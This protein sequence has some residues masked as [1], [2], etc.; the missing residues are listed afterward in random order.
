MERTGKNR[1]GQQ[2]CAKRA[3]I[4]GKSQ[5]AND[6]HVCSVIGKIMNAKRQCAC[7]LCEMKQHSPYR[8]MA[9]T[10]AT[11]QPWCA[12]YIG[13]YIRICADDPNA[14]E[15]N[16]QQKCMCSGSTKMQQYSDGNAP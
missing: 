12:A 11:T 2:G 1:K 16:V 8:E 14:A 4:Q 13:M 5:A 3:C 10:G 7:V 15:A 9:D 6:V